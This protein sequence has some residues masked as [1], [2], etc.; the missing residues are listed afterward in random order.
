VSSPVAAFSSLSDPRK[1]TPAIE[2][3]QR[4]RARIPAREQR[5]KLSQ[6]YE[7][8]SAAPA[9]WR[10]STD[11]HGPE[12]L[13][14][15]S[16]THGNQKKAGSPGR[17]RLWRTAG[18]FNI[19]R[20]SGLAHRR[21]KTCKTVHARIRGPSTALTFRFVNQRGSK[22]LAHGAFRQALSK[23][24]SVRHFVWRDMTP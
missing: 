10:R 7:S 2:I 6:A 17:I 13:Q 19:Q 21:F 22:N 18:M 5:I 1:R 3:I 8:P 24:D 20:S 4:R 16:S 15:Q 14:L 9:S 23:F 11:C 12:M